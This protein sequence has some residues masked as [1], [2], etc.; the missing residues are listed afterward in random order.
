MKW[1]KIVN[2]ILAFSC[3]Y[4]EIFAVFS[5]DF[6]DFNNNNYLSNC[7]FEEITQQDICVNH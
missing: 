7:G 5:H 6:S 1:R 3:S 2:V 4:L